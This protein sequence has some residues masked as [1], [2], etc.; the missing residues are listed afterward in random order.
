V[1]KTDRTSARR[2]PGFI[3]GVCLLEELAPLT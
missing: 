1:L 3:P 2:T